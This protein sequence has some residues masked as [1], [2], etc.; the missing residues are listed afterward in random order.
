[1]TS[2]NDQQ[3]TLADARQKMRG[4]RQHPVQPPWPNGQGIGL[5]LQ[6]LRVQVPQGACGNVRN[7]A[8]RAT[9]ETRGCRQQGRCW[10][11]GGRFQLRR[12]AYGS[13]PLPPE[14]V[15][16]KTN[17]QASGPP[18]QLKSETTAAYSEPVAY[19]DAPSA[20]KVHAGQIQKPCP[21]NAQTSLGKGGKLFGNALIMSRAARHYE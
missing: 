17:L 14:R 20:P 15:W 6:R 3:H 9:L 13:P 7:L 8:V 19:L 12:V 11:S 4:S 1:M 18:Q 5:L 10:P 16:I 2:K 21:P